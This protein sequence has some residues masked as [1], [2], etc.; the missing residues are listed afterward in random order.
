MPDT[1]K[2]FFSA[3]IFQQLHFLLQPNNTSQYAESEQH[4]LCAAFY[5][6]ILR[7]NLGKLS[8]SHFT[9][10]LACRGARNKPFFTPHF[11]PMTMRAYIISRKVFLASSFSLFMRSR[12][13]INGS[14]SFSTRSWR[15]YVTLG[16]AE[17]KE[18]ART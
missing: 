3:C 6:Y 12:E 14:F 1:K 18:Y 9:T 13:P 4:M 10:D 17:R 11:Y 5:T 15:I 7:G 8:S 16:A 2:N